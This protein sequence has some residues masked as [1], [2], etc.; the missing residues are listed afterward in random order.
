MTRSAADRSRLYAAVDAFVT[1]REK[2]GSQ[3]REHITPLLGFLRAELVAA[4]VPRSLLR[5]ATYTGAY[6]RSKVDLSVEWPDRPSVFISVITQSGSVRNNLT[7]RRREI[8]G[9]ALNLR[10]A[11][12]A[13]R[14]GVLYLIRADEEALRKR[15]GGTSA[16]DEL[17]TYFLSLLHAGEYL[18]LPVL[19]AAALIAANRTAS[20]RIEI[21]T[22]DRRLDVLDGF[23]P[24][25]LS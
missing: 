24:Q 6:F 5:E 18:P 15:D 9:D 21:E 16:I 4:G 7:N 8:L 20:R 1:A 10:T 19:D 12:P 2:T 11:H 17:Q 13:A 3:S 25:L 23:L 14:L 22:V